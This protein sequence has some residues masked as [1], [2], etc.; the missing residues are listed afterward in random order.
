[1]E[2]ERQLVISITGSKVVVLDSLVVPL[3]LLKPHNQKDLSWALSNHSGS[4]ISGM[5]ET[6]RTW[7]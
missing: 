6:N 7:H 2:A 4:E 1:M 3:L 5:E